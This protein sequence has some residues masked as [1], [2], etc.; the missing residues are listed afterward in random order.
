VSKKEF[1]AC[2]GTLA[3]GSSDKKRKKDVDDYFEEGDWDCLCGALAG[4]KVGSVVYDDFLLFAL[5]EEDGAGAVRGVQLKLQNEII[6]RSKLQLKDCLKVFQKFD[7]AEKGFVKLQD[8]ETCVLKLCSKLSTKELKFLTE[9]WGVSD[10]GVIDYFVFSSWIWVG[11]AVDDSVEK[12]KIQLS[13]ID[14]PHCSEVLNDQAGKSGNLDVKAWLCIFAELGLCISPSEAV[15]MFDHYDKDG[16]KKIDKSI[17]DALMKGDTGKKRRAKSK[18]SESQDDTLLNSDSLDAIAEAVKEYLKGKDHSLWKVFNDH[19]EQKSGQLSKR[20]FR[21]FLNTLSVHLNDTDENTL[22]DCLDLQEKG[23]AE[24]DDIISLFM[25]LAFEGDDNEAM[26]IYSGL[27][28]IKKVSIK[29]IIRAL[30]RFDSKNIGYVDEANFE[31]TLKKFFGTG[32]S[33]EALRFFKDFL[34]PQSKEQFDIGFFASVITVACDASRAEKKLRLSLE[35]MSSKGIKW[36][37][38]ISDSCMRTG[39]VI[40]LDD[41]AKEL[42]SLRL[43]LIESEIYAVLGKYQKKGRI[44]VEGFLDQLDRVEVGRTKDGAVDKEYGTMFG[45]SMFTAD[46]DAGNT[47]GKSMFVKICKLRSNA[48]KRDEFRKSLLQKDASNSGRIS[49]RDFL[50]ILDSFFD[51]TDQE[52]ALL[53]ENLTDFEDKRSV[54]VDYG[55]LLIVLMEPLSKMSITTGVSLL[56]KVVCTGI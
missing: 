43:P 42:K 35:H 32:V 49:K 54:D 4:A 7:K 31:K 14:K 2:I 11:F 38:V 8:F 23:N 56:S 39:S 33:T 37:E 5:D 6:G 19:D 30:R 3:E 18:R 12:L 36:K 48:A 9:K 53:C 28:D 45:K 47:F 27:G 55:L 51:L 44:N 17:L 25:S 50:R 22:F 40:L 15:A 13:Q 26:S 46:K 24:A 16:E 1:K 52:A 29:E 21:K 20:Q 10:D 41:M 34:T